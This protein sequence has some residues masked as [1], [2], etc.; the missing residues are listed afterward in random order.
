MRGDHAD[1]CSS[2]DWGFVH[3]F[4]NY[5]LRCADGYKNASATTKVMCMDTGNSEWAGSSFWAVTTGAGC[6]L[7]ASSCP[8]H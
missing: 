7:L 8:I 1:W 2:L 6:A 3:V 4:S 5:T